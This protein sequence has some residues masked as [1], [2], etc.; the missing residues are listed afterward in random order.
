MPSVKELVNKYH[1]EKHKKGDNGGMVYL[2]RNDGEIYLT[3]G[4]ELF[5]HRSFHQMDCSTSLTQRWQF[6][7]DVDQTKI[8]LPDEP[9]QYAA[10]GCNAEAREIR[11]EMLEN[12]LELN[13]IWSK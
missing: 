6:F 10:V 3:K 1:D 4:G 12:L 7:P 9:Y 2:I 8:G 5:G 11:K 13:A